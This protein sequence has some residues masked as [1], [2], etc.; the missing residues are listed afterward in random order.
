MHSAILL[1]HFQRLVYWPICAAAVY[2]QISDV[3]FIFYLKNNYFP[4]FLLSQLVFTAHLLYINVLPIVLSL[5]YAHAW[6]A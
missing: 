3:I 4:K 5:L 1:Y 2:G 6:C